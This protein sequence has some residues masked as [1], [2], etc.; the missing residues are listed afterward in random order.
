[1]TPPLTDRTNRTKVAISTLR[2]VQKLHKPLTILEY[3]KSYMIYNI[4]IF[5]LLITEM[6]L[7]AIISQLLS[8]T[9]YIRLVHT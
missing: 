9:I 8:M 2:T 6:N 3:I 4:M 1:M 5:K 7:Y